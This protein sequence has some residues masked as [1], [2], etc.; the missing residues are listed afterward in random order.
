MP[1]AVV[2]PLLCQLN[3]ANG[4]TCQKQNVP[5]ADYRSDAVVDFYSYNVYGTRRYL[6]FGKC[7]HLNI[8]KT[9]AKQLS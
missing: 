1:L 3:F 5:L 8:T 4:T 9:R 6:D 2:R 7:R